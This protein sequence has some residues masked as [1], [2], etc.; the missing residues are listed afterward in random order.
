[1]KGLISVC[2]VPVRRRLCIRVYYNV[3]MMDRILEDIAL[4]MYTAVRLIIILVICLAMVI[5]PA[6]VMVTAVLFLYKAL[7]PLM[8]FLTALTLSVAMGCLF[9]RLQ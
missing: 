6:L 8:G 4:G 3:G 2:R 7:G 9:Q 1:M 5:G